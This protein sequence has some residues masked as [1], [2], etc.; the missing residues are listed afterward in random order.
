MSDPKTSYVRFVVGDQRENPYLLTGIITIAR[1]LRD[2]GKLD[3]YASNLVTELFEW[4]NNNL[5]CPPFAA[6]RKSGQWTNDAVAWFK[7]DAKDA[8][9][10][11]WRLVA[12]L[13]EHD[14]Q[15][16]FVQTT[17]PGKIVYSDQYQVVAETPKY[18]HWQK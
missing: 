13:K 11:M 10:Q 2:D 8:I 9:N 4:F 5:P 7:D 14:V 16:R 6:N 15:V 12:I 18:P 1:E 17:V 3:H